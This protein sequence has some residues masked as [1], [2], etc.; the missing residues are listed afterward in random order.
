MRFKKS[1]IAILLILTCIGLADCRK[2]SSLEYYPISDDLKQLFL[3]QQGS[4][5]VYQ[6]DKSSYIDSIYINQAPKMYQE[7]IIYL[8]DDTRTITGYED[9]IQISFNGKAYKS[10]TFDYL[11][12]AL[13]FS[14]GVGTNYFNPAFPQGKLIVFGPD[15]SYEYVDHFDSLLINNHY[16]FDV[17]HTKAAYVV[18]DLAH[19][20]NRFEVYFARHQGLLK[21][22]KSIAGVDTTWTVL[23]C[24]PVQ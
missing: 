24:H 23:R 13:V 18:E 6:N 5:W 11:G 7:E 3:Y 20:T 8:G 16:Y 9:N 2:K 15:A 22:T 12:P 14:D 1:F 21:I 10:S 17:L 19:D 4:Y